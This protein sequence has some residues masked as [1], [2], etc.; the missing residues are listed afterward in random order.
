MRRA[1][2]VL[3]IRGEIKIR[4]TQ[5][6]KKRILARVLRVELLRREDLVEHI[7]CDFGIELRFD[8]LARNLAAD[9][10]AGLS[11]FYCCID[12]TNSF[13]SLQAHPS[14]DFINTHECKHTHT[15]TS[16]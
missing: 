13:P 6:S 9:V 4:I 16:P 12:S 1:Q 3:Q 5:K 11:V 15:N 2:N 10:I 8:L 7:L 14:G